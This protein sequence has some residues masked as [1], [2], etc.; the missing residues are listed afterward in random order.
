M[1]ELTVV[2]NRFGRNKTLIAGICFYEGK[3]MQIAIRL[4]CENDEPHSV[5]TVCL[6]KK[7]PKECIW[8]KG[9]SENDGM[10]DMLIEAG[11][12]HP[13]IKDVAQSG[14]VQ[15]YAYRMTDKLL[16]VVNE[17]IEVMA[18]VRKKARQAA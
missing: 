8:V 16:A 18:S 7:P 4:F 1:K 14:F 10:A 9:W 13:E 12:I 6:M 5:A 2:D 11:L 15:V 17:E 3:D